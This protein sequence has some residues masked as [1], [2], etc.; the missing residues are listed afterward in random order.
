MDRYESGNPAF[1]RITTSGGVTPGTYAAPAS[2]G[3]VSVTGRGSV[4]NLPSPE[5]LRTETYVLRPPTGTAIIGPKPVV[6]GTG[7]EVIFPF[8]F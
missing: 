1:S 5:I 8:G 2:E 4:Y 6:G 3:I 7:S